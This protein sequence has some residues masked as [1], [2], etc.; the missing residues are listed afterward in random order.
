[1]GL[2]GSSSDQSSA[3]A[4]AQSGIGTFA[5]VNK[6]SISSPIFDFTDPVQLA[7]LAVLGAIGFYVYRR[8]K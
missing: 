7:L 5:P 1:M 3:S 6:I 2:F 8:V 4:A